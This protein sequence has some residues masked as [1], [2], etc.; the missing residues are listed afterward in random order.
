MDLEGVM[1]WAERIRNKKGED[2]LVLDIQKLG[3]FADF[4]ILT[5]VDST[6]QLR[7]IAEDL[8]HHARRKFQWKPHVAGT[9]DSQWI[10]IDL[11]GMIIHVMEKSLRDYYQLEEI[12]LKGGTTAYYV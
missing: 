5:S 12:W 4:M 2:T 1:Q 8:E 6:P 10:V 9:W 11:G 7:A 3:S